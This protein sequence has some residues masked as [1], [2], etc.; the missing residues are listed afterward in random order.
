MASVSSLGVG[1]GLDLQTLVDGLVASEQQLRFGRL[2]TQA[3]L[4]TERISAYGLL[5]SSVSLFNG[6]LTSIGNI[7]TFQARTVSSSD[8]D[9]FTVSAAVN[10]A[11][12]N[13]SVEVVEAGE[14]QSL[15]GSNF[16]DI[17]NTA[18]N[19]ADAIIG[20]GT[21]IIQQGSQPSFSVV[22]DSA[23]SSLN[24]I[25]T[26]INESADNAGVEASVI[27]ADSGP[28]LVINAAKVGSDNEISI[29]VN[30]VDTNDTDAQGLS[31]LTF[32]VA[33]IA[34]SNLTQ[35]T[36]AVN[37]QITVNG[38]AVTSTSGRHFDEV[39]SGV[40]ITAVTETTI[41]GV[42]SI[43]KNTQQA[44]AA[45][46]EFIENFNA[47]S[48]SIDDL[49]RGG[50]EDDL[51]AGVLVGDSLLRTLDSQLRRTIFTAVD[52][53]QPEGVRTLSDIGI[54]ISRDGQLSLNSTKFNAL[55]DSNFDDV[56]RL[57]A[58]DGN[59][60]PQNNQFESSSFDSITTSFG[61]GSLE[62][63]VGEES[64]AVSYTT[65][66]GNDTLQG[67]RD[68]INNASNN[69]GITASLVLE[70]DGAGGT[71]A[72]LILTADEAGPDAAISLLVGAEY[73]TEITPAEIDTSEGVITRLQSVI[74]GFLGGSGQ[75]G[76]IDAR[77]EGLNL[78][79]ERIG[80]ERLVQEQ[81]LIAFQDRLTAQFAS[82]D[83]LVA[84]LQSNGN[85]LLSQL[86]SISQIS[87]NNNNR[88]SN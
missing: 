51:S 86:N 24:A 1:S 21:L 70:D 44:L 4:A 2:D 55:L 77:T 62:F 5:K 59:A 63:A 42:A 30:D 71:N 14:A 57:L 45:A 43:T 78:D 31:Q 34:G 52:E 10:A 33:D 13:Y 6:S 88:N 72:R 48:N 19:S 47:L 84:N 87:S 61:D 39:V 85:F 38:Q 53:T 81:R 15:T 83:L 74:E 58:A 75:Q 73:F 35:A 32:D 56:A 49:G 29:T 23:N 66:E 76:I 46:N 69:P 82:L 8:P 25:A 3:A 12:G 80:D 64:F 16:V 36:A 50:S 22:I 60:V 41:A 37:A 54:S 40:S 28:V 27:N 67:V 11:L 68:L 18:I 20:G 9:A 65:L 7:S 26:A 79:V 17:T